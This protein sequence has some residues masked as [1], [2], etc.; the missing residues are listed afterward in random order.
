MEKIDGLALWGRSMGA[1]TSLLCVSQ[2]DT[3]ES[4]KAM[5]LDSPF[6]S[7]KKATMDKI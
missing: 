2:N 7:L 4:I 3:Q 6:S 1:V 5:I